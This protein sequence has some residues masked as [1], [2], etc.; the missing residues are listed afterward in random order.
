[1]IIILILFYHIFYIWNFSENIHISY[2]KKHSRLSFIKRFIAF[3][4]FITTY[5]VS[6]NFLLVYCVIIIFCFLILLLY[7]VL[8]LRFLLLF[9]VFVLFVKS[10]KSIPEP[11]S[12]FVDPQ[13]WSNKEVRKTDKTTSS[14]QSIQYS[15]IRNTEAEYI[16]ET[17]RVKFSVISL[18][19]SYFVILYKLFIRASLSPKLRSQ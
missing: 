11:F 19:L 17:K 13:N 14:Y 9:R 7:L 8:M 4:Y 1:M 2:F 3:Y 10:A 15:K 6:I 5:F 18:L 12:S 16:N